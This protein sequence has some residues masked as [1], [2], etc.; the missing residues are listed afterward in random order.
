VSAAGCWKTPLPV[1]A[2]I[3]ANCIIVPV[4]VSRL[5]V[6]RS[7]CLRKTTRLIGKLIYRRFSP[8]ASD[9]CLAAEHS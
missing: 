4:F 9:T 7:V 3:T 8:D 2:L 1:V 5:S 6:R